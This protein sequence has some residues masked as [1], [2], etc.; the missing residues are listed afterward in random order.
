MARKK[1]G[2]KRVIQRFSESERLTSEIM[3]AQMLFDKKSSLQRESPGIR[4]VPKKKK[5]RNRF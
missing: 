1:I 2:K 3:K 5:K 4:L